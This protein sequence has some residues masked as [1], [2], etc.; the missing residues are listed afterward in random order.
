MGWWSP[1]ES[2]I[3]SEVATLHRAFLSQCPE[4]RSDEAD[5]GRGNDAQAIHASE[6][7]AAAM[8]KVE[9]VCIKLKGLKLKE[10]AK[11]IQE[12]IGETFTY[13]A[14]PVNIES[15]SERTMP[16]SES[17]GRFEAHQSRG[18]FPTVTRR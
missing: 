15:G 13:Y 4:C 1:W 5:A 9:A 10:A 12:S 6:D 3:R 14:F 7:L 18:A 8:E 16:W 11:K 17:C 2:S